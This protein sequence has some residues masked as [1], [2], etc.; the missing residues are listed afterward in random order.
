MENKLNSKLSLLLLVALLLPLVSSA[1]Y[2][3]PYS[4]DANF[5]M[6]CDVNGQPCPPASTSC[7]LT[8][9]SPA[10]TYLLDAVNMTIQNNG[11]AQYIIPA[12]SI[13]EIG[14]YSGKVYCT[15][16]TLSNTVTFTADVNATGDSRGISLFLILAISSLLVMAVAMLAQNEYIGFVGGALFIVTGIYAMIYGVGNLANTYTRTIGFTSIGLGLMFFIAAA[17]KAIEG[18]SGFSSREDDD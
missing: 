16:T 8:L 4:R 9:R 6:P 5:T 18:T 10:N 12:S 15:N 17:F 13:S 14:V 3:F 1:E 7:F 2:T 11:D